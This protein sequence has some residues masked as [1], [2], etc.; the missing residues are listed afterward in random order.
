MKY[1]NNYETISI[2]V[3]LYSPRGF[4]VLPQRYDYTHLEDEILVGG[5]E[6]QWRKIF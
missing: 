2:R 6:K 4:S 1:I 5:G 3:E